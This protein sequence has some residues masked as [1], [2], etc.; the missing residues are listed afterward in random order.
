FRRTVMDGAQDLA[1]SG[2]E[3]AAP[4][5]HKAYRVRP[6]SW[7]ASNNLDLDEVMLQR[8]DDPLGRVQ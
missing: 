7:I 2:T 5:Q 1:V 6:G 4:R 3:P 8:F